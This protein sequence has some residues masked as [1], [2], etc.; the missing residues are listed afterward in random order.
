MSIDLLDS[1]LQE[2]LSVV[3][4]IE[5]L[6]NQSGLYE[7]K[8]DEYQ[9]RKM[10]IKKKYNQKRIEK[11]KEMLSR[12]KQ[13]WQD[14]IQKIESQNNLIDDAILNYMEVN[15]EKKLDFDVASVSK[16]NVKANF[17]I[18]DKEKF[19]EYI[20]MLGLDEQFQKIEMDYT[21]AK[22]EMLNQK[23][24]DVPG[25]VFVPEHQSITTKFKE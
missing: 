3:N 1:L 13:E 15:K 10:L 22:N 25:L 19:A 9:I 5:D 20:K 17:T 24:I 6:V 4:E 2:D 21:K 23:Q 12:I 8:L 14:M 16:R 7:L 11:H 18:E